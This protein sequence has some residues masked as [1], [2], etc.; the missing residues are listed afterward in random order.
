MALAA[1]R[2]ERL[3]AATRAAHHRLDHHPLLAAL[4]RP[5]VS[6]SAQL[7]ALAALRSPQHALEAQPDGWVAR[8]WIA[9]RAPALEADLAVLCALTGQQ[10]PV[11]EPKRAPAPWPQTPEHL[12]AAGYVLMGSTLGARVIHAHLQRCAQTLPT[13]QFF[14]AAQQ[15]P[16]PQA[17]QWLNE[18]APD[19]AP[20]TLCEQAAQA[21]FDWILAWF[22]ALPRPAQPCLAPSHVEKSPLAQN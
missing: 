5:H 1:T 17:M 13:L 20:W 15:P 10:A 22:D 6:A 16:S 12:D 3:R 18:T 19:D 4:M 14:A 11:P 7:W 2:R 8:G 21:V 9:P